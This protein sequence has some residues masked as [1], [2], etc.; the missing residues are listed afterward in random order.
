MVATSPTLTPTVSL[1]LDPWSMADADVD[2][3][4]DGNHYDMPDDSISSLIIG[5]YGMTG[6]AAQ[7]S[8]V[9]DK[10]GPFDMVPPSYVAREWQTVGARIGRWIDGEVRVGVMTTTEVT[11]TI[12]AEGRDDGWGYEAPDMSVGIWGGIYHE[13]RDENDG[14]IDCD[15]CPEIVGSTQVTETRQDGTAEL[16]GEYLC[17]CGARLVWTYTEY[18]GHDDH[19]ARPKV[20]KLNGSNDNECMDCDAP[21]RYNSFTGIWSHSEQPNL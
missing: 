9:T 14:W 1:A 13:R 3:T 20:M 5:N 8:T 2:A 16:C 4:W 19:D 18:V 12:D 10:P 11:G 15:P 6:L 7:H 17:S 21:I